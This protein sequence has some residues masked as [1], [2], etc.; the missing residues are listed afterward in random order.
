M[1][2]T[3]TFT[4]ELKLPTIE[5]NLMKY[6]EIRELKHP[7]FKR[8]FKAGKDGNQV[9]MLNF[10]VMLDSKGY[11]VERIDGDKMLIVSGSL[12]MM[13][14]LNGLQ[15]FSDSTIEQ[16][17]YSFYE[18]GKEVQ[19]SMQATVDRLTARNLSVLDTLRVDYK[20]PYNTYRLD[21]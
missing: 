13:L 5:A 19:A 15:P 17:D 10:E 4:A 21:D 1:D 2:D 8:A 18:L 3:Y 6:G 12:S 9:R 11:K 16:I 20:M 14:V 7:W